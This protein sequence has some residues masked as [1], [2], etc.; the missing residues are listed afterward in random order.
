MQVYNNRKPFIN[1]Q[2]LIDLKNMNTKK[3]IESTVDFMKDLYNSKFLCAMLS[4]GKRGN[5]E[6]FSPYLLNCYDDDVY[7]FPIFTSEIEVLKASQDFENY[8]TYLL[9]FEDIQKLFATIN[10]ET[11]I[12]LV[13]DPYGV[14]YTI[15]S[16]MLKIASETLEKCK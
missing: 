10:S 15:T 14:Q 12:S 4:H 6:T 2:I 8:T 11:P 16:S 9:D 13:I 3:T 5:N 7:Y 1:R